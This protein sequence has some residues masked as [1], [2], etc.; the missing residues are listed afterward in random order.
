[1]ATTTTRIW[2]EHEVR[3]GNLAL[4]HARRAIQTK[5]GRILEAGC[6]AGRFI[7]TI[8]RLRP[9]L[10][11]YG[12]DLSPAAIQ[13]A[14]AYA[15]GVR[16]E[17]GS[18]AD[19]PY[20]DGFFDIV[21]LFDVLEHVPDPDRALREIGRVLR[22]G[23]LFHALIPCEGQAG[24]LHWVLWKIGLG[25]DLKLRHGEH[26]QRFRRR[27]VERALPEHGFTI[28]HRA[29]SMHPAGQLK[30]ILF[31]VAKEDWYERLAGRPPVSYTHL[32]L[33]TK[34]IV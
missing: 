27:D 8:R 14:Q 4:R 12:A 34:R 19:L 25:G 22:P 10:D 23:G 15:D 20:P 7:R 24:T 5:P 9:D 21:V 2:G 17:I 32:T 30:D 31:Y 29:Y 11:A 3:R 26:I 16:Y 18:L 13:L 1:M 6:G 28:V 33:P